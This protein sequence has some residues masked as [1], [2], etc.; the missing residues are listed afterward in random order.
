MNR[1][2]R[3]LRYSTNL[4]APVIQDVQVSTGNLLNSAYRTGLPYV[5][6]QSKSCVSVQGKSCV[7][8]QDKSCVSVQDKSC[9]SVQDK[10]CVSV[11]DKSCVSVQDRQDR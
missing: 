10:S 2:V 1:S 6:L 8:V 7:S 3:Y 4:S 5:I 9:V 11:Q